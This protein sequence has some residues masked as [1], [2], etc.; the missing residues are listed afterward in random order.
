MQTVSDHVA[1]AETVDDVDLSTGLTEEDRARREAFLQGLLPQERAA[2]YVREV[3]QQEQREARAAQRTAQEDIE[4]AAHA[5]AGEE[6]DRAAADATDP[7]AAAVAEA[8]AASAAEPAGSGSG[9]VSSDA[10]EKPGAAS[11]AADRAADAL[12]AVAA[13][14]RAPVEVPASVRGEIVREDEGT[15]PE[16]EAES[17]GERMTIDT[18]A[19]P[20]AAVT[21]SKSAAARVTGAELQ[22][23][24]RGRMRARQGA[25]R[26]NG[27]AAGGGDAGE[28]GLDDL[29]ADDDVAPGFDDTGFVDTWMHGSSA[30]GAG[31]G[32]MTQRAS[33]EPRSAPAEPAAP[34]AGAAEGAGGQ[35][36]PTMDAI[37]RALKAGV[38][39]ET[40]KRYID[41]MSEQ[42]ADNAGARSRLLL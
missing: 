20:A 37:S 41:E 32:A 14:A 16:S 28:V 36:D 18:N 15:Q 4:W 26:N 13:A 38:D 30:G 27:A 1:C 40:L 34:T 17:G 31:N 33:P 42:V 3:A 29:I 25:R 22:G 7:V 35:A 39:K 12:T 11:D 8:A 5:A 10:G 2:E 23:A 6:E 9:G 19:E 21:E 24:A